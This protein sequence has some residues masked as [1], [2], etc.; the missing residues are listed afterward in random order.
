MNLTIE[1]VSKLTKLSVPT[2]Y[3]YASRQKLGKKVGNRKVFSQADV[4]KLLKGSKKSPP[5]N[6]L[7]APAKKTGR[8]AIKTEPLKAT[9][10][11]AINNAAS[12]L[13][14]KPK[15]ASFW[16]RLFGGRKPQQKVSLMN[17]KATK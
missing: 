10:S 13:A 11:K 17:A 8:R 15:G 12:P 14:A 5:K 2:L 9:K 1:Q 6:K 16:G 3:V 7:K 4:Q